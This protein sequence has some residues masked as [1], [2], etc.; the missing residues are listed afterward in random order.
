MPHILIPLC[1]DIV[2]AV[3]TEPQGSHDRSTFQSKRPAIR[4]ARLLRNRRSAHKS[5]ARLADYSPE[6]RLA[7]LTNKHRHGTAM[8]KL[9][10]RAAQEKDRGAEAAEAMCE[11]IQESEPRYT[12]LVALCSMPLHRQSQVC[13][14]FSSRVSIWMIHL[15][16]LLRRKQ[17]P[18]PVSPCTS[19]ASPLYLPASPLY[20]NECL[21]RRKQGSNQLPR[22]CKLSGR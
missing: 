7:T 14:W 19:P 3:L 9:L 10:L 11:L 2:S 22:T 13:V 1:S 17:A 12:D 4:S 15:E 8:L 5:C 21:L 16:C 6:K 18:T 20:L